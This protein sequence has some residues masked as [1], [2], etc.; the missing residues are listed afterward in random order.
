VIATAALAVIAAFAA[1]ACSGGERTEP[2]AAAA[3]PSCPAAWRRGWQ[4]LANRVQAPVYCPSWL[5]DPLT[6]ELHGPWNNIYSVDKRDRSYL[7]GFIWVERQEEIHVNL[8]GYPDSTAIPRCLNDANKSV[9]CFNDIRAHKRLAGVDVT[10]YTRN[11]DADSWHVLYAWRQG[12]SLYALSEHVA[13]PFSY[14]RVV[15]NLDRM[16]RSLQVIRPAH[17][18]A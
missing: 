11:R 4:A 12:G 15:R 6:G 8:R 2:A 7:I 13:P 17:S 16:M 3:K 5:P 14:S 1:T 10:M 18:A 9:P